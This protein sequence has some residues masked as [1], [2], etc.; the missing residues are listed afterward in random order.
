MANKE[1]YIVSVV[2]PFYN[3]NL[4][5]FKK[6]LD[7]LKN[8]TL[9]FEKIEWV[10]VI[11]NSK[12]EYLDGAKEIVK[13]LENVKLYEL[14]NDRH[15]PSSPRNYALNFVNGKYIGFLD[16]DDTYNPDCLEKATKPLLENDA[17]IAMFRMETE[18]ADPG[19]L[20]VRQLIFFDQTKEMV[21]LEKGKWDSHNLIYGAA[22]NVCAKLYEAEYLRRE[23]I[24]F[25][26]DVPFAEDNMFNLSAFGRA[27]R[28]CILPQ[29]IGYKYYLN[30]GSM[31]QTFNKTW[32]EVRRYAIGFKKVFETG[33]NEG[34]FMDYIICDLLG[35]E[36][37]I[38]LASK[39]ITLKNRKEVR[40]LL[41]PFTKLIKPIKESKLYTKQMTRTVTKLP[42]IVINHPYL[43]AFVG[44]QIRL[45]RVD[46]DAKIRAVM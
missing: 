23:G 10:V 22:L 13:G 38:L 41:K 27:E 29:L 31:V 46:V 30:A 7:S 3:V 8:Q 18:S 17:Q 1:K 32:D 4:D 35:Y 16:A 12:K 21:L 24:K 5:L 2:T 42:K 36:S 9:G 40:D 33:L 37:A 11:H 43:M 15:T 45:L 14:N 44:W 34:I 28:I 26:E 25:D 39:N 20:A 6:C 19:R